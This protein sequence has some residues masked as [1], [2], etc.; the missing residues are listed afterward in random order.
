MPLEWSNI[1]SRAQTT[2]LCRVEAIGVFRMAS[3]V[4][5]L[6]R[7]DCFPKKNLFRRLSSTTDSMDLLLPLGGTIK[8]GG[9]SLNSLMSQ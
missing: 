7:W 8:N 5:T 9:F 1:L 2:K 4:E 6:R 3:T